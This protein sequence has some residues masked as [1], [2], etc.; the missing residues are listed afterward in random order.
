MEVKCI[1]KAE[2]RIKEYKE[3]E[4]KLQNHVDKS[5]MHIWSK[6]AKKREKKRRER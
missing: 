1:Y 3:G 5:E 2:I 4:K 6:N